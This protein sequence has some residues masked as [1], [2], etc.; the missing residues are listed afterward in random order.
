MPSP[1]R[2]PSR[3]NRREERAAAFFLAPGLL[4][5]LAFVVFPVVFSFAISLTRWDIIGKPGFV[6]A[7]NY[8]HLWGDPQFRRYLGNTF[9]YAGAVVSLG[10]VIAL[11]L[12]LALNLPLRG[13]N[14]FRTVY[15]LP[16]AVSFVAAGL[17][18]RW[19]FD[20]AA[21]LINYLLGLLHLRGP[22]WALD[23]FWAWVSL[24][25]VAIW[26]SL[27]YNMVIFLAALQSIPAELYEAAAI[28]GATGWRRLRHITMPLLTPALFFVIV[29]S[30]I[31]ALQVFDPIYIMTQG[32]PARA[33]TS[34]VY[35]LFENG[36]EW[37][38]MGYAA[39]IAWYL[40]AI[41]MIVTLVQWLMAR[42]WVF[43]E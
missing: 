11:A 4:G 6:G 2:N 36:F 39:A 38:K 7:D 35:Y 16:V 31:F 12:A 10:I 42:R 8:A 14:I 15:F 26:K 37:F 22:D 41:L 33:T 28:D 32:G 34:L 21:G 30:L 13:R 17:I 3:R 19:M 1:R 29:T 25:V 20:P 40:F 18:W 5:V 23:P 27:G 24:I 43:Y 9:V